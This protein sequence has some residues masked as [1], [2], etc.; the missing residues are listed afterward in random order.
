MD[1]TTIPGQRE[2]TFFLS[3]QSQEN[4]TRNRKEEESDEMRK[5]ERRDIPPAPPAAPPAAEPRVAPP[6]HETKGI[7]D[8]RIPVTR[9]IG[10]VISTSLAFAF[11]VARCFFVPV[12]AL[13]SLVIL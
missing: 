3:T 13:S 2:K 8:N 1:R 4:R 7:S 10:T 11:F 9:S 12:V 6:L 5:G